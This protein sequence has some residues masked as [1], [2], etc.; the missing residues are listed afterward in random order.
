[1]FKKCYPPKK[2]P[3]KSSH[4]T[5][6]GSQYVKSWG[7]WYDYMLYGIIKGP[8]S[9]CKESFWSRVYCAAAERKAASNE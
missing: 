6:S 2:S 9:K 5:N 1:M 8:A 3:K 7:Q 4:L